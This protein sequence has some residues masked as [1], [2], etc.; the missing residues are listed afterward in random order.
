MG[1]SRT[2]HL[3]CPPKIFTKYVT[4]IA[5]HRHACRSYIVLALDDACVRQTISGGYGP[6]RR[7]LAGTRTV[8]I[9]TRMEES[10]TVHS[11]VK[12]TFHV[13]AYGEVC[14]PSRAMSIVCRLSARRNCLLF[15][16]ILQRKESERAFTRIYAGPS[17][18]YRWI[19]SL[20]WNAHY[21]KP[22]PIKQTASFRSSSIS[23]FIGI[24]NSSLNMPVYMNRCVAYIYMA[25]GSSVCHI[26]QPDSQEGTLHQRWDAAG[27]KARRSPTP[28]GRVRDPAPTAPAR[29]MRD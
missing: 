8:A 17:Y 10:N 14:G 16:P 23:M 5:A 15:D 1:G 25:Y 19:V 9:K 29:G 21:V 13:C 20:S 18:Y 11:Y 12:R 2:V 6:T 28:D 7:V 3:E 27:F 26:V 22:I 4:A 24:T